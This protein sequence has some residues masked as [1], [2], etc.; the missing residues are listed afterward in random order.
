MNSLSKTKL[1]ECFELPD[2]D[3]RLEIADIIVDSVKRSLAKR[4]GWHSELQTKG[5]ISVIAFS[6]LRLF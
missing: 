4:D 2:Q 5:N 1:R 6:V 3:E